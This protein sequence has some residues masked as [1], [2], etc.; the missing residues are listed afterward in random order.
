MD[1][2]GQPTMILCGPNAEYA[3][4]IQ[5]N[6]DL[7]DFYIE[8]GINVVDL[9]AA[10]GSWSQFVSRKFKNSKIQKGKTHNKPS[11][12]KFNIYRFI[13]QLKRFFYFINDRFFFLFIIRL[14]HLKLFN[15]DIRYFTTRLTT[16]MLK[17]KL[18][19]RRYYNLMIMKNRMLQH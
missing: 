13:M 14:F 12:R 8:N 2:K 18:A 17:Q 3:E 1:Y 11:G 10:P 6:T 19:G 15:C 9:G 5:Y 16:Q 4:Q 7:L